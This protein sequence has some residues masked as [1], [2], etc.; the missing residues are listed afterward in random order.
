MTF[1]PRK[2]LAVVGVG[3]GVLGL[4]LG[5]AAQA[6]ETESPVPTEAPQIEVDPEVHTGNDELDAAFAELETQLQDAIAQL[7]SAGSGEAPSPDD[8]AAQLEQVLTDLQEA[9]GELPEPPAAPALPVPPAG[10]EAGEPASAS[11]EASVQG[12]GFELSVEG[13]GT[14]PALPEAPAAPEA[15]SSPEDVQQL[16]EQLTGQLES[17][18]G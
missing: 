1:H 14:G 4:G 5:A 6:E 11:G 9:A 7:E 13:S 18:G 2:A 16:L 12:E 17:L 8:L 10:P 3:I 15:P